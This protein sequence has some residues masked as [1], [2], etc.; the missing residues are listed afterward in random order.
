[1]QK[2]IIASGPVIVRDEKVLL[3]KSGN[4]DF[5]KFCGGKIIEGENLQERAISR[6]KEELGVDIK[7]LDTNPFLM[8][9]KKIGEE[10]IDVLLVHYLAD[11]TGKV[12]LGDSVREWAWLDID[13]LP[14]NISPNIIPALKY[15]NFIKN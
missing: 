15:F 12:I 11:F 6:A 13:N 9:T 1:M 14:N 2:I 3:D 7:I 8:H 5:W 10:N 4:D